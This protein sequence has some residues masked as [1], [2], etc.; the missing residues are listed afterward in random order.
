MK[1][2]PPCVCAF[3]VSFI[4]LVSRPSVAQTSPGVT[5]GGTA[6][7]TAAASIQDGILAVRR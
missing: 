2:R 4:C 7:F 6:S 5:G 1:L 3:F